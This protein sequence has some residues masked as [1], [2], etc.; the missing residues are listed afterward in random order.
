M[1]INALQAFIEVARLG[2]FSKAAD[3]LFVTQ[4]AVSKRIAALEDELQAR[5]FDRIGKN[6]TLTETGG[7]LLPRARRLL[8]EAD[9]MKRI[10]SSLSTSV[11]GRLTMGTS[12]HIGLHRLPPVLKAFHN[13]YPK[14]ILD[15]RFM[16]SEQACQA[17]EQGELE[18]AIVTLPSE[19]QPN[20]TAQTIWI[21]LLEVVTAT[22]H[23]LATQHQATLQTLSQY[24]AVL[25]GPQTYTHQ[26][27]QQQ[28]QRLGLKL[29]TT[30]STNYLE[31]LKMLVIIGL[32][33]SLLPTTMIDENL[34]ELKT[35]LRLERRLGSVIHRKRTLSNAARA[36]L[37]IAHNST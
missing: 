3:L 4:P 33:W 28:L 34:H 31:T 18:L 16:D 10:A 22:D 23:P 29:D 7:K 37:S 21:D 13:Q 27:L 11:S 32:G 17:V 9:E 12:H 15:L 35:D 1:E 24:P 30:L 20:L 19:T 2:S 25:P 6:I 5:L 14:V 8:L 36:M 26:I